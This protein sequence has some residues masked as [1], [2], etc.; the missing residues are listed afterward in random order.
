M[1]QEDSETICEDCIGDAFL[2]ADAAET[3]PTICLVCGKTAR[4]L[5]IGAIGDRVH[6]VFEQWY[7]PVDEDRGSPANQIIAEMVGID[8]DLAERIVDYLSDE[9]GYM[10][11]R[12][13][14]EDP[15]DALAS[16]AETGVR[17]EVQRDH[18]QSF[19]ES[20]LSEARFFNA[21]VEAWLDDVFV[22]IGD[23]HSWKGD[24]LVRVMDPGAGVGFYRARVA[25]G[26]TELQ[27]I[28]SAP[29]GR[30]GPPPSRLARV[31]RMN[32][33]GISV[34]YGALDLDTCIAEIRPPVGA[35]VVH[36]RFDLLKPVRLLDLDVAERLVD[37][38]SYFDP[39]HDRKVRRAA[40]LR[41]IGRQIAWP[42]MP[43]DELL[44][45][46]PT[47]VIAEYLAQRLDPPLDGILYH[48]TQT[49]SKGRNVVLFNRAA[50]VEDFVSARHDVDVDSGWISEDDYDDS[51]TVRITRKDKPEAEVREPVG[52]LS[53]AD[54]FE[55][56]WE[57]YR[58]EPVDPRAVTLRLD[59]D[60]LGVEQ[61]TATSFERSTRYVSVSIDDQKPPS[62][63][64]IF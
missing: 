59:L 30:L 15:Y 36:G 12:D 43:S 17:H 26:E 56:G 3:E 11:V 1:E 45:Y 27:E 61:I 54:L 44:G 39:D 52:D 49:G 48:S 37:D 38:A 9:H 55:G 47:Q 51:I 6:P 60:S 10:A 62:D 24:P 21:R 7:H 64:P 23:H 31:G 58:L 33:A 8:E 13:G 57:D 41:A 5:T 14:G 63:T 29:P 40:I 25:H 22:D 4:G 50:R 18:W 32:A 16:F 19:K 34:F 28:L 53:I 46:L 20:L 35:H 42:V 2:S